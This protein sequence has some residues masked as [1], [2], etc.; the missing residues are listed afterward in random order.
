MFYR[1]F[2]FSAIIKSLGINFYREPE[3]FEL[4]EGS[5]DSLR[6][7]YNEQNYSLETFASL[8]KNEPYLLT[9][10]FELA[11][12]NGQWVQNN[13]P[14]FR[15]IAVQILELK[16]DGCAAELFQKICA[17]CEKKLLSPHQSAI[18][19]DL[20]LIYRRHL[21]PEKA[22]DLLLSKKQDV[23]AAF[24]KEALDCIST[25]TGQ[26]IKYG[27]NAVLSITIK[28]LNA[29]TVQLLKII[30]QLDSERRK[31][32]ALHLIPQE[33]MSVSE[34]KEIIKV[35]GKEADS[36][37]LENKN[38]DNQIFDKLIVHCVKL[39]Q[40]VIRSHNIIDLEALSGHSSLTT[41]DCSGCDFLQV[42]PAKLPQLATLNCSRSRFLQE[43]PDF[44]SLASLDCSHCSNLQRLPQFF[45]LATLI[46]NNC[47]SLQALPELPFLTTLD[48]CGCYSLHVLPELPALTRLD[49]GYCRNFQRLPQFL[50]LTSLNCRYCE[51]LKTLPELPALTEFDCSGC[52]SLLQELRELSNLTKLTCRECDPLQELPELLNL[53]ELDCSHCKSLRSLPK[54]S[55]LKRLDCSDCPSLQA[56][57]ELP[58]LVSLDC[59]KCN[60]LR[61]LPVLPVLKELF[62]RE[63]YSFNMLSR[64]KFLLD[65]YMHDEKQCLKLCDSLDVPKEIIKKSLFNYFD[66]ETKAKQ[67]NEKREEGIEG[68]RKKTFSQYPFLFGFLFRD[69]KCLGYELTLPAALLSG[70]DKGETC[71][72]L[73]EYYEIHPKHLQKIPFSANE[74]MPT[75]AIVNMI[76]KG[77]LK[78]EWLPKL[79]DELESF[80]KRN[81]NEATK[82]LRLEQQAFC[83]VIGEC[84]RLSENLGYEFHIY[85]PN[86]F[87]K[88]LSE[89]IKNTAKAPKNWRDKALALR[90]CGEEHG[91]IRDALDDFIKTVFLPYDIRKS[92]EW[93]VYKQGRAK[94]RLEVIRLARITELLNGVTLSAI[95]EFSKY[96]HEPGRAAELSKAKT[97]SDQQWEPLFSSPVVYASD[98]IS[99]VPLTTS[100]ELQKEGQDLRHCVGGYTSK[101]LQERSHIVSLREET[102]KSLSTLELQVYLGEGSENDPKVINIQGESEYHLKLEQ[103]HGEQNSTPS[104]LCIAVEDKFLDDMRSGRVKVNLSALEKKR[105]ERIQMLKE[106]PDIILIGYDPTDDEQFTRAKKIYRRYG[107]GNIPYANTLRSNFDVLT[108]EKREQPD[109]SS[110]GEKAEK[111]NEVIENIAA[112]QRHFNESFGEGQVE[113]SL[114]HS[115]EKKRFGEVVIHLTAES[116]FTEDDLKSHLEIINPKFRIFSGEKFVK[117]QDLT[118][119]NVAN[120]IKGIINVLH[121][122]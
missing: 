107:I 52:Y 64:I 73:W 11:C 38:L 36:L 120:V 102:G 70:I 121:N 26:K 122:S 28:H 106:N 21:S 94:E 40:L 48:C 75:Q 12:G 44:P 108:G 86:S 84:F 5:S 78:S 76:R 4:P 58:A 111:I 90:S 97:F 93:Q 96:W 13:E 14:L 119:R 85:K 24:T 113:V 41:L 45:S 117:I 105:I 81:P 3:Y 115:Q 17:I 43:L 10:L 91:N 116:R 100:A 104:S 109:I 15:S 1:G 22:L 29:E 68:F 74:N 16:G 71:K 114:D 72:A 53:I 34:L 47:Q 99:V 103:H 112:I 23:L 88:F 19:E 9:E 27:E 35:C 77:I 8:L 110:R 55:L 92:I 87:P 82:K 65:N 56:L 32:I 118:P 67:K 37:T 7:F 46:C 2:M 69:L 101:C 57:P 49:C 95:Y 50:S 39:N 42:L 54:L 51:S 63:C 98:S 25:K 33:Q 31:E 20:L 83:D 62:C 61:Y 79:P 66:V 89:L 59:S 30:S 18:E 6:K 60:S 80:W